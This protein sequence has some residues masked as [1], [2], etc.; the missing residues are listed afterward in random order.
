M[1]AEGTWVSNRRGRKRKTTS[2]ER[3]ASVNKQKLEWEEPEEDDD[4]QD[5]DFEEPGLGEFGEGEDTEVNYRQTDQ[6]NISQVRL[7]RNS[8][9]TVHAG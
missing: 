6:A 7:S 9:V 8:L 4:T 2:G 1:Q 5:E 3:W